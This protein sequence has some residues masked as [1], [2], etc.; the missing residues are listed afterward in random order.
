MVDIFLSGMS[1]AANDFLDAFNS[2]LVDLQASFT[3]P[4]IGPDGNTYNAIAIDHGS[5]SEKRMKGGQYQDV[6]VTIYAMLADVI[7]SGIDDGGIVNVRGQDHVVLTI[8]QDGD[9]ART[10]VCGSPQIDVWK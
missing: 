2:A 9:D 4:W 6:T 7:A 5:F 3:E 8:E 10:L 1:I